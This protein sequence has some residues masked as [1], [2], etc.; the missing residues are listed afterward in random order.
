MFIGENHFHKNLLNFRVYAEFE[1][2]NENDNSSIASKTNNI[3]KRNP[4]FIGY[5]MVS[6]LDDIFTK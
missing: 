5:K 1:A 2:D 6:E 4:I 3:F